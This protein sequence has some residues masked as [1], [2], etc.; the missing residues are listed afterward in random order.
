MTVLR[1]DIETA[2]L[3]PNPGDVLMN[4]WLFNMVAAGGGGYA[5]GLAM[6]FLFSTFE[7]TPVDTKLGF[8]S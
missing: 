5:I 2:P 1:R 6:G 4:S 7:T 3:K 8:K